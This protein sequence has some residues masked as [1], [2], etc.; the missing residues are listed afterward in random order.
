LRRLQVTSQVRTRRI[1]AGLIAVA[2]LTM[3]AG[4][5]CAKRADQTASSP[6]APAA[7]AEESGKALRILYAGHPGSDRERD[8]VDYLSKHFGTVK[9]GN[10]ET[11]KD[12]DSQD[13]DVTLLDYD[14]DGFKAP[15]PAITVAFTRPAITVGVVGGF[16]CDSLRLKTGYL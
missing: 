5:G 4:W 1:K 12:G 2:M 7:V 3:A 14:G 16:I 8:F 15:R 11:F 10:L 13:F 9:T 6:A